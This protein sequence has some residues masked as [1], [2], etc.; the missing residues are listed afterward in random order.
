MKKYYI[1]YFDPKERK[2]IS[3]S[4]S[5]KELIPTVYAL[6]EREALGELTDGVYAVSAI[7][8]KK[9]R[10]DYYNWEEYL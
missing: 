7:N 3:Y 1:E 2:T 10:L 5:L 6:L 4:L 9:T 8:G